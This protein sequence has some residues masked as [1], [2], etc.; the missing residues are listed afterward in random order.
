MQDGVS[1]RRDLKQAMRA[2]IHATIAQLVE[3]AFR[4]ARRAIH[5][6]AAEANR[7]NVIEARGFVREACEELTNRIGGRCGWRLA[8][9]F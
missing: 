8:H 4:A 7:H 2:G 5:R 1:G 9:A 6:R 3:R